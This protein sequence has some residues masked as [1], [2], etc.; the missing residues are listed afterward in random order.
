MSLYQHKNSPYWQYD[1]QWKGVRFHGTTGET[2]KRRAQQVLERIKLDVKS[3]CS[4]PQA[5]LNDATRDYWESSGKFAEAALADGNRL[6][7][8]IR[9]IGPHRLMSQ[10][11]EPQI[12]DAIKA[13][14]EEGSLRGKGPAPIAN[15]TIN[16]TVV[17]LFKR[18]HTHARSVMKVEV[19]EINWTALKLKES[20]PR[21][22]ELSTDDEAAIYKHLRADMH[23][24]VKFALATGLRQSNVVSLR[25]KDIDLLRKEVTVK[26]KSD[27]PGRKTHTLPLTTELVALLEAE[28]QLHSLPCV[29]TYKPH[30]THGRPVLNADRRPM[31]ISALRPQWKRALIAAKISDFRWHDLRHTAGSRCARVAGLNATKE[32]LGHEDIST[33]CRYAHVTRDDLRAAMEKMTASAADESRNS[34]EEDTQISAK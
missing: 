18:I 25:R 7:R 5:T 30:D 6:E 24:A 8:L 17:E 29:F 26:V 20:E 3:G 12:L 1:F 10:I 9:C 4:K 31:T 33:T 19:A 2:T 23:A 27:R 14:R 16:R 34:P 22:R 15:A 28:M 32:L 21:S 11:S 13:R